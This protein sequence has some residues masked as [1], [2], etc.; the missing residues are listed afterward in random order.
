MN[1]VNK[2]VC[3]F[4]ILQKLFCLNLVDSFTF[5]ESQT[6]SVSD[7]NKN[8]QSYFLLVQL[9][10]LVMIHGNQAS[11]FYPSSYWDT[12]H[13]SYPR[14]LHAYLKNKKHES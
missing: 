9:G 2:N 7:D 1:I 12:L 5:C 13:E 14:Y 6:T 8:Y 4:S 11:W 3:L 10:V